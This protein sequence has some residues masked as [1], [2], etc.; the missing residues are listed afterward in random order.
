MIELLVVS[1][2]WGFSFGLIKNTGI[3][4]N[5]LAAT[6]LAVAALIFFPWLRR[7]QLPLQ[8]KLRLLSTGAVQFGLMYL[9]YNASFAYLQSYE[10]A[11][12]T[13]LTPVYIILLDNLLERKVVKLYYL[14]VGLAVLGAA[15]IQAAGAM[16]NIVLTGFILVQISNLCFAF[17]Q[18]DYKRVM[19]RNPEFN[20]L[21]VFALLFLGGVLISLASVAVFNSWEKFLLS[22]TQLVTILYLGAVASGLGFFLWNRGARKVNNGTLA[23]F[24]NLK[25]PLAVLVSTIIFGERPESGRLAVGLLLLLVSLA[26]TEYQRVPQLY[27]LIRASRIAQSEDK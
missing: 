15:L 16:K 25:I 3:D 4:P 1:L 5:I 9:A 17:G 20:N 14:A 10:V 22:G 23:V 26:I 19:A 13:I 24:N 2:L 27:R 8:L 12:F 18:V 7:N 21:N 6:R 11:L